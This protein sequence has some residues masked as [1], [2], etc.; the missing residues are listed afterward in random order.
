M[1]LAAMLLVHLRLVSAPLS[2][3]IIRMSG[4]SIPWFA[5]AH[6]IFVVA[7]CLVVAA[8]TLEPGRSRIPLE[9]PRVETRVR[10]DV[11]L[12]S[13]T[14]FGPRWLRQGLK[15]WFPRL[16]SFLNRRVPWL[17]SVARG[18]HRITKQYST[19]LLFLQLLGVLLLL[20][21]WKLYEVLGH[22]SLSGLPIIMVLSNA[23]F[24]TSFDGH[25]RLPSF[26]QLWLHQA[27]KIDGRYYEL[28][29]VHFFTD[30][31]KLSDSAIEEDE[32]YAQGEDDPDGN[33]TSRRTILSEQRIGQ[34]YMTRE[35]IVQ[36]GKSGSEIDNIFLISR[37]LS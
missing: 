8:N 5:A 32:S 30:S 4:S 13:S 17:V 14:A 33:T 2:W 6:L 31:I 12:V 37:S 16:P 15:T 21:S 36:I 20:T 22:G 18:Y 27:L 28:T 7:T 26:E 1:W 34:T 3:Q 11:I 24:R 25:A 35:E 10:H 19:L 29:W 9:Q 23:V